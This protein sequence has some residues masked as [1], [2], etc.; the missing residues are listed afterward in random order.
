MATF[1]SNMPVMQWI[2]YVISTVKPINLEYTFFIN[3][4]L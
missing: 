2:L 3:S 4:M 1:C